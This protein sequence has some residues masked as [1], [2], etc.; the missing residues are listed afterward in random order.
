MEKEYIKSAARLLNRDCVNRCSLDLSKEVLWISVGQKAAKL[1]AF[2]IGSLRNKT[3]LPF[4]LQRPTE[5]LLKD[6][7]L[8]C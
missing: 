4:D 7:Y 8:L 3:L 1:Q 2:K 5:L 6:L